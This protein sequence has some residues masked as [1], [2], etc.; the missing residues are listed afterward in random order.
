MGN[1]TRD[2]WKELNYNTLAFDSGALSSVESIAKR[3]KGMNP[4]LIVFWWDDRES[5]ASGEM[6]VETLPMTS[7]NIAS[8]ERKAVDL[9]MLHVCSCCQ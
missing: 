8:G 4:P 1:T 2:K 6:P 9:K 7:K 3:V 5:I